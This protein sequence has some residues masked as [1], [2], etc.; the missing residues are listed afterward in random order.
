MI[1]FIKSLFKKSK[2]EENFIKLLIDNNINS[3]SDYENSKTPLKE[4]LEK[5]S[6]NLDIDIRCFLSNITEI[7]NYLKELEYN[8]EY[9]KCSDV[10]KV[11]NLKK[12]MK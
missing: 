2:L 6:K 9:E 7:D 4:E 3:W 11:M 8:E 5:Y 12:D 1:K 10:L